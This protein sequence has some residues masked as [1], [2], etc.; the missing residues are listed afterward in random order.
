MSKTRM[1]KLEARVAALE[2]GQGEGVARIA[3]VEARV[4]AMLV[5]P[6]SDGFI[7]NGYQGDND[8]LAMLSEEYGE[9]RIGDP[10]PTNTRRVEELKAD[11]IVGLYVVR[12]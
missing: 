6:D 1:D 4:F 11:G 9:V 2:H 7:T 12:Q 3:A 10:K 8:T 5:Q